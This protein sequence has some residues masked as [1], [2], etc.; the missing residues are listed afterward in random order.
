ME[1]QFILDGFHR[2]QNPRF[3]TEEGVIERFQCS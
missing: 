3:M 1:T 2:V